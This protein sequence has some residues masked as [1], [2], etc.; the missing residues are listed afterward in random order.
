MVFISVTR[1]RAIAGAISTGVIAGAMLLCG[2]PSALADPPAGCTAADFNQVAANVKAAKAAYL[3]R[4]PDVNA[5]FTSLKGQP[6]D[7]RRSQVENYLTANPQTKTELAAIR[8]PVI[9]LK[10]H[11]Q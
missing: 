6:K 3:F 11:C 2:M 8:Q 9:D 1:R 7:Q 10:N 4:H 5:F